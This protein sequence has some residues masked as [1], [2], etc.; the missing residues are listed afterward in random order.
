MTSMALRCHFPLRRGKARL[1]LGIPA[2]L[3]SLHG[4]S[5]VTLL[6]LSE[7]GARLRY[8]GEPVGDVVIEWLGYEA[9]GKVV[10][11]SGR[12]LGVR[13]DEPIAERWV[14]DTRERLPAIARGED[15]LTRFAREWAR[16]LDLQGDSGPGDH[17]LTVLGYSPTARRRGLRR[18][19]SAVRTWLGAARPFL[20][21]GVAIGLVAGYL[22]VF[23]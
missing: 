23:F 9:F 18:P 10:R 22:S 11:R 3:L 8:D 15:H 7:T 17:R 16:G 6:D 21:G 5:R 19:P 2:Q 14:L 12:E 1:R 20:V 4:R 13:F